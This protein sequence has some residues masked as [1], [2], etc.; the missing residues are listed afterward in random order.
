MELKSDIAR[1]VGAKVF[2]LIAPLMEL[3]FEKSGCRNKKCTLLIAPLMELKFSRHF[4]RSFD[5]LLLI[6]PLMELKYRNDDR[7]GYK[8]NKLW[9]LLTKQVI[10]VR[11]RLRLRHKRNFELTA[12]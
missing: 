5:T 4:L 9:T 11:Y 7:P 1:Q 6:A 10:L 12:P 3:K 2:L 8:E